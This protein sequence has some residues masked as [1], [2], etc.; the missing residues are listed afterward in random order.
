MEDLPPEIIEEIAS[1][2][3]RDI[4]S[5][6]NLSLTSPYMREVLERLKEKRIVS[7]TEKWLYLTGFNDITVREEGMYIF[8]TLDDALESINKDYAN[9][10]DYILVM[11]NNK[12][13]SYTLL[14][15]LMDD[16]ILRFLGKFKNTTQLNK[17]LDEHN[18]EWMEYNYIYKTD[19]GLENNPY[20]ISRENIE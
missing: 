12:E 16:K 17:F 3:D 1:N 11:F 5:L 15:V 2:L 9:E 14:N 7:K 19:F 13:K 10:N 20:F 6:E 8:S 4:R 18:L